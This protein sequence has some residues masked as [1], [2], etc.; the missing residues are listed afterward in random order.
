M[1][2]ESVSTRI[3][4]YLKRAILGGRTEDVL[5]RIRVFGC[6][7]GNRRDIDAIRNEE[8]TVKPETEC[9]NEVARASTVPAFRL[10]KKIGGSGLGQRSL[11]RC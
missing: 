11:N 9:T 4:E 5:D 7:R 6:L 10:C 3:R 8:A 2:A 1:G